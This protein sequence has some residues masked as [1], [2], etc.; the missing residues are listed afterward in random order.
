MAAKFIAEEGELKG[1]T[2]SL[3]EGNEWV[4]GRDPEACQL[5]VEDPLAS[6]KHLLC[7]SSPQGIVLENLSQ[8]NPVQ[9]NQEEVKEPRLLKHG[10]AVK[11]GSGIFRFY[12]ELD[13]RLIPN[14][15]REEGENM[16]SESEAELT[17]ETIYKEISDEDKGI[18]AEIDFDL[19]DTG[20]WLLKV[21]GG[22]NNGAEFSM[23]SGSSYVIGTDPNACDVIFHDT[24]VSRQHA[25]VTISENNT[26]T[27]EDLKS[28]N[29]IL[30]EEEKIQGRRSLETNTLVTL[31]TTS[32][33]IF[34][35]EGDMQTIISPLL[36]SIVKVLQKEEEKK[37]IEEKKII[38][39]AVIENEARVGSVQKPEEKAKSA[40]GTFVLIGIITG[41]F[42]LVGVGTTT[43]FQSAPVQKL[44][45]SDVNTQLDQALAP[46]PSITHS[47]NKGT[48]NLLLVGHVLTGS[49]KNQLRYNL[50]GLKF[51]KNI[52]DNGVIIDEYVWRETNLVL[53]RDSRWKGISIH[54][55]A[56]GTF[57]LDGFLQTR[58][59]AEEL[60]DYITANFPY[61]DLLD[62]RVIIGEDLISTVNN[63]LE[64]AGI[65]NVKTQIENQELSLSGSIPKDKLSSMDLLVKKIR[66][67][68]GIRGV[69][70]YITEVEPEQSMINI[71]DRYQVTGSSHQGGVNLN[72]VI[73]GRILTRGD[74][75]DG[76][77]ITIIRPSAIFLEKDGI[78]YRIDYN[79][80]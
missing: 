30:I 18:L 58:K 41:L 29:G 19:R 7:R 63:E 52:D 15:K 47:F 6:R 76:M 17:H 14:T 73:N 50:E 25:R 31:G 28:R 60:S 77:T 39:A 34:D 5:L 74:V 46:F 78:K 33:L 68:P 57:V 48:G 66:E 2:L 23:Q 20:R 9:V 12:E 4:I 21:I 59:Q 64:N 65:K 45:Q 27:I 10:D 55:P 51:I 38:D 26:I 3:D 71:T 42:V 54:S 24:S 40:L 44:E 72:V 67:I 13:A 75:L 11:I 8:T 62:R 36:P 37:Q 1:L 35:R 70:T 16:T 61:L 43:L 22:P 79:K 80:K 69:K 53:S 32:F 56:P 49:D